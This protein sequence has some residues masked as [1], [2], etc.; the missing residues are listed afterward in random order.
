MVQ[1]PPS[2]GNGA[3]RVSHVSVLTSGSEGPEGSRVRQ[4]VSPVDTELPNPASLVV[5]NAS[6][7]VISPVAEGAS[8]VD[9]RGSPSCP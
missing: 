7:V 5:L 6:H 3:H 8:I 9:T 4:D 1:S 2:T